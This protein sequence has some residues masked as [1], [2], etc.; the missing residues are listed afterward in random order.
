MP[1]SYG[2]WVDGF[3]AVDPVAVSNV[4][5]VAVLLGLFLRIK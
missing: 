5:P 3:Q 1:E 4:D 2:R